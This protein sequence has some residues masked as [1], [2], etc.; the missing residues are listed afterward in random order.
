MTS[1]Q[2]KLASCQSGP[3]SNT[4]EIEKLFR[5][6]DPHCGG[7][8]SYLFGMSPTIAKQI[9]EFDTANDVKSLCLGWMIGFLFVVSFLGGEIN[10]SSESFFGRL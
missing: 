1:T 9:S 5:E 10:L 4:E 2:Q 7:F 6:W 3:P 8:G